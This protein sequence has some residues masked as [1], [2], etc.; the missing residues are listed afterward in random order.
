M[1]KPKLGKRALA[2]CPSATC[3]VLLCSLFSCRPCALYPLPPSSSIPLTPS[4][5]YSACSFCSLYSSPLSPLCHPNF[6][7]PNSVLSASSSS[8]LRST[9]RQVGK[10]DRKMTKAFCLVNYEP[11]IPPPFF[12]SPELHFKIHAFMLKFLKERRN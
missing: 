1:Y 12:F 11:S 2:I 8:S 7:A 4:I 10:E 5:S 3:A 9:L 6:F